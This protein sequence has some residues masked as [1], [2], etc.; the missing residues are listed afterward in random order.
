MYLILLPHV[1][2]LFMMTLIQT[3]GHIVAAFMV[4]FVWLLNMFFN[5]WGQKLSEKLLC[6]SPPIPFLLIGPVVLIHFWVPLSC[7]FPEE[8]AVA[9]RHPCTTT[10]RYHNYYYH[11]HTLP[12]PLVCSPLTFSVLFQQPGTEVKGD[13]SHAQRWNSL[14]VVK[15]TFGPDDTVNLIAEIKFEQPIPIRVKNESFFCSAAEWMLLMSER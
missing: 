2:T 9:V 4:V 6:I 10:C 5:K 12:S 8:H 14:E 3:G 1:L 11:H 7:T 13:V 15:G